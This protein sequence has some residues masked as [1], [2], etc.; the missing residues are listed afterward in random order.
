MTHLS[1]LVQSIEPS[2]TLSVDATARRLRDAGREILSLG[3]GQPDFPTPPEICEAAIAAIRQGVGQYTAVEGTSEL[4]Q[5]IVTKLERDNGL[6]YSPDRIVVSNGAKHS[7]Y[8]LMLAAVEPGDGVLLPVPYWVSYP[9][10]VKLAGG[11]PQYVEGDRANACKITPASLEARITPSSR[12]LVLNSPC[13]PSGAVYT[14]AELVALAEVVR[15]H[16]LLVITDEIYEKIVY[17]GTEHVSF[18]AAAP[19]RIE[20]SA[21]VNGVSKTY[22]M[23]GWRIG[24]LAAP[25]D[26]AQ[27][28]GKLQGQSTGNA[29]AA[30]QAAAAAA[31][32]MPDTVIRPM[33]DAYA[34]RR[35]VVVER[36]RAIEGI[37]IEPPAGSFY[38][39]PRVDGYM[40]TLG[41]QD[42]MALAAKLLEEAGVA[43]VPGE[44]FGS[45]NFL[46]LSFATGL[47]VIE[48]ALRKMAALA[49]NRSLEAR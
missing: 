8:N 5:A 47:E 26:L 29:S 4:R 11:E 36:L 27:A 3:A 30:A 17:D 9:A 28:V 2:P 40:S 49:G 13:N 45:S 6:R 39:F 19:D 14:R 12:V 21:L 37:D 41:C 34:Q 35:A 16:D 44:A 23:T 18:I 46:R 15:R 48:A 22:A 24:Y 31:L 1:K 42:S 25:R 43:V 7:L 20:R 33:L 10:M 32:G 38:A